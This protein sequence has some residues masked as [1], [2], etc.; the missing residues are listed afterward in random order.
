M[1]KK[2]QRTKKQHYV[3]QFYLREFSNNKRQIWVFDKKTQRSFQT[4][5]SNVASESGFYDLPSTGITRDD[6][7]VVENALSEIEGG[8]RNAIRDLVTEADSKHYFTPGPSERNKG[9]ALFL[10]LQ[11]V[12]TS[13]FRNSYQHLMSEIASKLGVPPEQVSLGSEMIALEHAALMFSSPLLEQLLWVFLDHMWLMSLNENPQPL[14]TSDS[15]VC[16]VP[17]SEPPMNLGN[18]FGSP[19]VVVQVPLSSRHLLTL[20]ERSFYEPAFKHA[21]IQE[22]C[23]AP[24]SESGLLLNNTLQVANSYRWM[25]QEVDNFEH[26]K[27]TIARL[28]EIGD[29][30]RPRFRVNH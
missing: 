10:Y 7:Q 29:P 11:V 12:R 13:G 27:Y 5:I 21:G 1:G 4:N 9:V 2:E 30:E 3:P 26:A 15:P 20:Y 14:M 6:N 25:Y 19:G 17:K 23:V 28:P 18:G 22:G 16:L 8:C 24:L